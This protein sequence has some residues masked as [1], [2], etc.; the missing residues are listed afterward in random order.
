[1]RGLLGVEKTTVIERIE[2]DED[3]EAV[4]AHVHVT[5]RLRPRCGACGARAPRYDGGEGRRRWRAL[6]LGTVPVYLEAEAP[7]VRCRG[8]GVTVAWVPWARHGA[9]HT[10]AFDSQVAWLATKASKSTVMQLMRVAW[11]TVGSIVARVWADAD[12]LHDR[13]EGLARIGIDEISYKKGHKYLMV[14]VDH[15][16]RQ[17]VWAAPGRTM[18]TLRGFFDLLGEERC[19][20]ITHVSADGA[21]FIGTVVAEKCPAAIRVADPFHV[22]AWANDA[23]GEVRK[24]SWN[25]ARRLARGEARRGRG[26]PAANAP[27]RPHSQRAKGLKGAR[28]ALLKNPE[29]LTERQSGKLAW[30]VKADPRLYRAYL[31]KEGLRTVFKLPLEDAS[32]ALEGWLKWARRCRI[33]SFVTLAQKITKHRERILAAIEHQLSNGLIEST[34]TKIRLI[35]RM[36]FGF[37]TAQ[38]LIALAMLTLGPH[39]PALPGR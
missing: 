13:F 28:F 8:H 19:K 2:Y 12:A 6:D 7:R 14:V 31:L 1:L 17:L 29:N 3:Q 39:R 32:E 26:R 21:D 11:R 18:D 30:I 25:Q 33:P 5:G 4:V 9:G 16:T 35:T 20:R 10:R 34:N 22:V 36:A 24:E 23:L 38:P 15:D 37:K 27:S